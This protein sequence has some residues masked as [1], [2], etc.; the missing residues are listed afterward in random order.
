MTPLTGA[1]IGILI[2]ASI[3]ILLLPRR[4]AALPLLLVAC[5]MVPTQGVHLFSFNFFS[6]RL[7]ILAGVVR[8]LLRGERLQKDMNGIDRLMLLWSAWA[9][10]S[11]AF[12]ED[13]A[14]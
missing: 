13:P 14:A 2:G 1:G 5:Y 9:L 3:S 12:H 11:S 8:V 6:V 10:A 7:I 4:W